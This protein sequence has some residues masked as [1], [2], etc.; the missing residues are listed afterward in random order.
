MIAFLNDSAVVIS[1]HSGG[2]GALDRTNLVC[3][4]SEKSLTLDGESR[5]SG[6]TFGLA[7]NL[8]KPQNIFAVSSNSSLPE[9]QIL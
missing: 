7:Q 2:D 6:P 9:W 8:I 4:E 1:R 3:S 5:P